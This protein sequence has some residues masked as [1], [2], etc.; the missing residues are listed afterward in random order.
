MNPT[1]TYERMSEKYATGDTPWTRHEL[2]PQ[3][4]VGLVARWQ[5]GRAVDL[6][7]AHGRAC[8]YLARHGWLVDGVDFIPSAI[9]TARELTATAGLT[10]SIRYW[11]GDITQLGMLTG[12][13]DFALDVGCAHNLDEANWQKHHAELKRLVRP[14]GVYLHYGRLRTAEH[15]G[16]D[17]VAYQTLMAD[18]FRLTAVIYGET[19]M[20][21]T[22]SWRS[23]WYEWQRTA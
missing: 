13:Y 8:R 11:V 20:S 15:W 3:E 6:G 21:P 4:V 14:G 19:L 17:D 23:A 18:G 22:D 10:E 16:L 2:P 5:P 7:C 9:A 1:T 12:P